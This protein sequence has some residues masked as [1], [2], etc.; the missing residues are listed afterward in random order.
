M[1]NRGEITGKDCFCRALRGVL[2]SRSSWAGRKGDSAP[3]P[4]ISLEM[5]ALIDVSMRAASI[6]SS[7]L[8]VAGSAVA[9][10]GVTSVLGEM[11]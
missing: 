2:T 10:K 6:V 4:L 8:V 3:R 1:F 11:R 5:S 7:L 9:S